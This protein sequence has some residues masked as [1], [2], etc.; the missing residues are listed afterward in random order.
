M[1]A[2]V[3]TT[4]ADA[5]KVFYVGGANEQ[6]NKKSILYSKFAKSK[7]TDVG[8]KTYTVLHHTGR[9][10]NAG[11]GFSEGGS[12]GTAGNQSWKSSTIPVRYL[13][14]AIE[15]TG[16]AIR[17]A[18]GNATSFVEAVKS[19]V[20]M[21]NQDFIRSINR[22]L[23]GDG[24]GA[25]GYW[26]SAD[27]TSG[28][29]I[30]DGR[31]NAFIQLDAGGV[32]TLDLIDAS[33]ASTKV[34]DSI[35]VTVGAENATTW[36]ATWTGTVS[37]SADGDW[38]VYEDSLGLELQGFDAII[39]SG[40]P[41]LPT[42]GLQGLPVATYGW[43]KAQ[44][45]SNSGTLRDL[46]FELM[47]KPL[48]AIDTRSAFSSQDIPFLLTN[49][50]LYDKYCAL[51]RADKRHVNTMKLDGGQTAVDFN[52]YPLV[53]DPQALRNQIL[54][55]NPKTIALFTSSNGI[56]W[57]DFEDG[58]MFQKKVGSSGHSD[59]YMAY[60]VFYGNTACFARNGNGK[61]GDISE[62]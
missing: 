60:Q 9:N 54:Y 39:D 23:N 34:G 55:P 2:N 59:A 19:E 28:T 33:D 3:T 26:T 38:L 1:A 16:P 48:T 62:A 49:G 12:F 14:S 6:L 25:L 36:D 24:T 37:G 17:A 5:L 45:F 61:L 11:V 50:P 13:R 35:V 22:Q 27:N 15:I 30:D 58:Q 52:G 40:D 21:V 47:Q 42:L 41:I 51:C 20:D 32:Y 18:K 29:T 56:Q 31:G 7:Q 43:W 10:T 46:T 57:A 8:G 53:V 4:L 44:E